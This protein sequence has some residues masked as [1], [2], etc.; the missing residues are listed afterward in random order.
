[1]EDTTSSSGSSSSPP[2]SPISCMSSRSNSSRSNS[3]NNSFKVKKTV[4]FQAVHFYN[5][6]NN[7]YM[8]DLIPAL[9]KEGLAAKNIHYVLNCTKVPMDNSLEM[10]AQ[11][12]SIFNALVRQKGVL[13]YCENGYSNTVPVVLCFLLKYYNSE[14][15]LDLSTAIDYLQWK[16]GLTTLGTHPYLP[17]VQKYRIYLL[18]L[19]ANIGNTGNTKKKANTA[20]V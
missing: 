13:V 19:P 12:S 6:I 9:D 3:S 1:M 15:I 10:T 17:L 7:F 16:T 8:S 2:D 4:Q 11:I 5:I 20:R 14:T 18:N